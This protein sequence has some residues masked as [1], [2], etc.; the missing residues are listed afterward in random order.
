MHPGDPDVVGALGSVMREGIVSPLAG[1]RLPGWLTSAGLVVSDIGSS[2]LVQPP[3]AATGPLV[4]MLG[5]MA[6]DRGA[7]TEA[8]RVSLM[9]DLAA[10]AERGDF[11]MS[12]TMFAVVARR[13]E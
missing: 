10:G 11:L 9:A 5:R 8:Q 1:R 13:P 3:S 6:R 2:A 4:T 7:I 12:V